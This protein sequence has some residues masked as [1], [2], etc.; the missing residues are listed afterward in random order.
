[1]ATSARRP[2]DAVERVF[3]GRQQGLQVPDGCRFREMQ[4]LEGTLDSGSL[5]E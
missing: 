4:A 1:M 3:D 5:Q 2:A